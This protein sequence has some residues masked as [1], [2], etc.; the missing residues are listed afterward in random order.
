MPN[1]AYHR[2]AIT[3]PFNLS[4]LVDM[5][6]KAEGRN[7][8]EFFREA[9]RFYI[10]TKHGAAPT[11]S[12]HTQTNAAM[13]GTLQSRPATVIETLSKQQSTDQEL[14]HWAQVI[15]TDPMYADI[16]AITEEIDAVAGESL[17]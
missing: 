7:R 11:S 9:V 6:C 17:T 10:N 2:I 12:N 5:E 3:V 4:T 1:V 14:M 16:R 13:G 15:E 8:S